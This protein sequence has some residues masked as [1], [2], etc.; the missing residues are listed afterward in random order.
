MDSA[1]WHGSWVGTET[2]LYLPLLHRCYLYGLY[3][4]FAARKEDGGV[5]AAIL[6]SV[7]TFL[8]SSFNHI[9]IIIISIIGT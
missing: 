7:F 6:S 5:V 8:P 1:L 9:A 2:T 3:I 4:N